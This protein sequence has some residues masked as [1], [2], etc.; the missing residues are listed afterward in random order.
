MSLR[1]AP[2]LAM[3]AALAASLL[4]AGCARVRD[5]QGYILNEEF[6]RSVQPGVDNR[7]SVERTLGR[8]SFVGQFDQKD[9]FYVAR[10]TRQYGFNHPSPYNQTVLRVRFDDSGNVERIERTGM[11]LVANID[12]SNDKTPTLGSSRS[13]FEEIFGNIGSGA[14]A[15]RGQ[16]ADNP[17]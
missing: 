4:S 3:A 14:A 13:F 12:P 2:G 11:E 17:Q 6:A 9:W 5:Q 15:Q 7:E 10:E 8:P 1:L 16:T